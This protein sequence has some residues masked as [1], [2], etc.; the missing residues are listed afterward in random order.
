MGLTWLVLAYAL[1][2]MLL[3]PAATVLFFSRRDEEAVDLLKVRLRGMYDRLPEWLK[4]QFFVTDNDHEWHWSNGS[5]A[6]AFPTTGG[7][8]YSASLVIVDEADLVPDLAKLM[9]SVKPTIDG[10]G[11]MI[12]VSRVDKNQPSSP[13]KRI[14]KAARQKQTEWHAVF[15]PW[16]ARPDRDE[17]WYQAQADDILHRTGSL[18]DL[19]EQYPTFDTQALFHRTLN[20]RIAPEW[21]DQCYQEWSPLGDSLIGAPAI[22]G[23]EVYVRPKIGRF[24]VIGADPAEG[25]PTSDDSALT[26]LDRDT[27]EEVASLAGKLQPSMLA[28][29]IDIIG[30]WYNHSAV[31]VERNNHGHAVLLWLREHSQLWRLLGHDGQEGWLS[32]AKGKALLY[33]TA[34]DMVRERGTCLHSFATFTQLA[35]I[36]GST[37]RAPDGEPDD[38]ADSFA[39]ASVASRIRTP[40]PYTGPLVYSPYVPF[41]SEQAAQKPKSSLMELLNDLG[42]DIEADWDT[43]RPG[44]LDGMPDPSRSRLWR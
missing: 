4:V 39:L 20:K 3:Q 17:A 9:S 38:R 35:S 13:F 31:L 15:L 1:W 30:Q 34:A 41:P 33:D 12:L 2:M 21:M 10:G 25:N 23:L 36:E 11:R 29:Y 19:Y 8:S 40:E 6:L 22:P 44:L 27:G 28:A 26:V 14:Y 42:I 24:Y 37:L 16:S 5:R 7:D 18:D 43:G 32:N